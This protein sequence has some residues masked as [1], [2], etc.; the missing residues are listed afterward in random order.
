MIT[1]KC[2]SLINRSRIICFNSSCE[3]NNS[4]RLLATQVAQNLNSEQVNVTAKDANNN[5]E[6]DSAV[7][8]EKIPG[9]SKLK[10]LSYF[11]PGG[12]FYN[13]SRHYISRTLRDEYGEVVKLQ[14]SF[15]QRDLVFAYNPNHFEKVYRYDGIWPSRTALETLVHYRH[16]LRPDIFKETGT[17]LT[18]NGEQWGKL[19][20]TVNPIMMQPKTV[21]IYVPRMDTTTTKFIERIR[22]IRDPDTLELPNNFETEI[23]K[24]ALEQICL[25]GLD[26]EIGLIGNEETDSDAQK[27]IDAVNIIFGMVEELEFRP[28]LWKYYKTPKYKKIMKAYDVLTEISLKYIDEATERYELT[29]KDD[30]REENEK[31]IVERLI[32]ID[33]K[34]AAVVAIEMFFAGV[35]TTSTTFTSCLLSLAKNP[36][37]QEIL[38]QEISKVLPE[39][40]T[41]I[42]EQKLKNLPYLRA[43]IKES[44]RKYPVVHE[45]SRT[46]NADFVLGKYQIPKNIDIVMNNTYYYHDSNH[47]SDPDKFIPERWLRNQDQSNI[48]VSGCPVTASKPSNPFVYLPFG[49][50]NRM[51]VG[52]RLVDMELEILLSRMVRNFN[53]EYN[54]DDIAFLNCNSVIIDS[55]AKAI[56]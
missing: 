51:C 49:F 40:D 45:Q 1:K 41:P 31:S 35:D 53:I 21:R 56:K 30:K 15:K 9:P 38:R 19:R 50:G 8:Y 43:V 13:K 25:V 6:W 4:K 5:I 48:S 28:S 17:L 24:W 52:K 2:S 44:I 39:R 37:K 10:L 23:N 3:Y 7:P 16:D 27:L 11:L 34:I 18:T 12:K 20:S 46:T 22:K 14:G 29:K 33:K 26:T 42:T 54:Y 47:F 55:I 32:K 36:E